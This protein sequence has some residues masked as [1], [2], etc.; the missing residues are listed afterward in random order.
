MR[1]AISSIEG[2]PMETNQSSSVVVAFARLFWIFAGPAALFLLAFTIA[3]RDEAWF[4]PT[5]IA[6][7]V[8]VVGEIVARRLDPN[9]SYGE[10]TTPAES[11]T[12]TVG[13]LLIGLVAWVIVNL[14]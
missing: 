1:A 6:F 3:R 11:N 5:S 12:F 14:V 10:P 4:A 9:N 13:A 8:V 7:L 2:Y